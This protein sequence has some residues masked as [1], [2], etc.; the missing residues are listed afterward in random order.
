M[1]A[2]NFASVVPKEAVDA[3]GAD[4]GKKPVG[5]GAFKLEE[6]ALGQRLVFSKHRLLLRAALSRWLQS[7]NRSGTTRCNLRDEKGEVDIAG[8][9][10]PPSKYVE[11]RKSPIAKD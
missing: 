8:D 1:L 10:I 2:L 9:G 7:R 4:F 6:W 3:E 11:I 5:S